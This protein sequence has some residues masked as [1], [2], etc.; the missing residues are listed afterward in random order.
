MNNKRNT[1]RRHYS[2]LGFTPIEFLAFIAM[3]VCV[4]SGAKV[5]HERVGG[6]FG[7]LLGGFF[8]FFVFFLVGLAWAALI[9]FGIKGVPRLPKCRNGCCRGPGMFL[10][11]GDYE[12]RK[13]GE[14]YNRV[15]RC[16]V[17]YKRRGKR[18]VVV[19]DDGT[20]SPYLIWRP[21]RGWF[22]DT[23]A[24]PNNHQ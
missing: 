11:Y 10:G 2:A 7:W 1:K 24:Q 6:N 22:P 5:A 14:E 12:I 15:C 3:V 18:F 17:R 19:N 23:T 4:L 13:F 20:E 21:F 9:D 8:G 16:G